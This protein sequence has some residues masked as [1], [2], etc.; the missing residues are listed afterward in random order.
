MLDLIS[1]IIP[2]IS[3]IWTLPWMAVGFVVTFILS[4]MYGEKYVSGVM[5]KI[6]LVLLFVFIPILIFKLF[7]NIDFKEDEIDFVI[8]SG[9]VITLL[10]ALA[11]VFAV[12]NSKKISAGKVNRTHFIKTVV[13]NQGRSAA[14]FGSAILSIKKLE[15]FAAIYLT[16]LGI[17][18]FAALPYILSV[19]HQKEVT[20]GDKQKNPLPRY[21]KLYPWYLLVFPVSA[22]LIHSYAGITTASCDYGTLLTFFGA[23]TIPAALYYVGAGIKIDDINITELKKLFSG[24]D[25]GEMEWVRQ[26]LFLTMLITPIIVA[27]AC[28]ILMIFSIIPS[29]WAAVLIINSILP[30]TSTNMFLIPYGIDKKVTALSVTWTTF[31]SI[32]IFLLLLYVFSVLFG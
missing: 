23:V 15:I 2:Y 1:N 17:F 26:I 22:V 19:I 11:Y 16:L 18:L 9:I 12:R 24:K 14:F 8:F 13:V 21:L 32:P 3:G 20:S 5:K 30:I 6:G 31:F 27:I 7:L 4:K 28:G 29:T 10:Y 25:G